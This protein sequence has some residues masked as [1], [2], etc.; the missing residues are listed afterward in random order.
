MQINKICLSLV[1]ILVT[2]FLVLSGCSNSS[3]QPGEHFI[4]AISQND[5]LQ[6]FSEL[7]EKGRVFLDEASSQDLREYV[8]LCRGR[9]QRQ[10]CVTICHRP[11]GNPKNQ[12]TLLLP[13]KASISHLRHG[14]NQ[15]SKDYLGVCDFDD[16][17]Q[18][19][20]KGDIMSSDK[21]NTQLNVDMGENENSNQGTT[22]T[23]EE[24]YGDHHLTD[25]IGHQHQSEEDTVISDESQLPL[26]CRENLDIDRD[27]DGIN[28]FDQSFLFLQ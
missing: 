12:K 23:E 15:V 7:I 28:D 21:E 11:P 25:D 20:I 8:S 2:C 10:V 13:L 18:D 27:C 4:E 16:N 22:I 6:S 1:S 14:Y 24:Q 5:S 9:S 26:W 17:S 19:R 3:N